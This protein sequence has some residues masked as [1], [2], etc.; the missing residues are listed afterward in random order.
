MAEQLAFLIAFMI[1]LPI[2]VVAVTNALPGIVEDRLARGVIAEA[3]RTLN[4]GRRLHTPSVVAVATIVA[5][6]VVTA[7]VS[8]YDLR[9]AP[10]AGAIILALGCTVWVRLTDRHQRP[11]P[12]DLDH[13]LR[14]LLDRSHD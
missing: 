14:A 13:E 4:P 5:S 11:F 1:G 7:A 8:A 3:E 6:G 9:T 12:T 2:A 10:W